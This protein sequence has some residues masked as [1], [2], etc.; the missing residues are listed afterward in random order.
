MFTAITT[1]YVYSKFYAGYALVYSAT[2]DHVYFSMTNVDF[3]DK[4]RGGRENK[5]FAFLNFCFLLSL[6][7]L[8][9]VFRNYF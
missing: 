3:Y 4:S 9:K 6:S 5:D 8:L 2:S 7:C 1:F